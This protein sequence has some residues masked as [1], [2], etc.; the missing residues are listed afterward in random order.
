MEKR[1]LLSHGE[2]GRR[3]HELISRTI[4]K[5]LSCEELNRL[6]D[7]AVLP[8]PE[9]G[10]L[11][12]TTD[13]HVVDPIFFPGG[14]I[15]RLAVS[16]TV[17]DLAVCGAIPQYLSLGLILEEGFLVEDLERVLASIRD[18][19]TEAGVQI[20]TGDT[21][22]VARGQADKIYINTSGVGFKPDDVNLGA[23]YIR[24]GDRLIVSGPIGH[25]G[26]AIMARRLDLDRQTTIESDVAPI[27]DVCRSAVQ[28]GGVKAIRDATRGGMATVFN[29]FARSCGLVFCIDERDVPVS[30]EVV[31]LCEVIG[32][33]PY[34]LA[35]EGTVVMIVDAQAADSVLTA[36]RST[37]HGREAAIIGHVE[38]GS[39]PEVRLMTAFGTQRMLDM[40]SGG[41]FPRIC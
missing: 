1:I 11:V 35:N 17:N 41:Q 21:K 24:A 4:L 15:G 5:Y 18:T 8:R 40:L 31:N 13:S 27:V 29:E 20:V 6:A 16:G 19:A 36:V 25:H 2:G 30:P 38:Q 10:Q 32:A 39:R 37:G 23:E 9:A 12:F 34:Y 3:T 28:A 14:D 7:S 33:E 26:A 22:V